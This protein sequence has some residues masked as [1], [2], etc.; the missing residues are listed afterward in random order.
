MEINLISRKSVHFLTFGAVFFIFSSK[1]V[2]ADLA[3]HF[4]TPQGSRVLKTWKAEDFK[5]IAKSSGEVSAL[6]FFETSAENLDWKDRAEIDLINIYGQKEGELV[7]LPRFMVVREWVK[8]HY[9]RKSGR[10]SIEVTSK[11]LTTIPKAALE[12]SSITKIELTQHATVYPGIQLK[13]RTNP[14][15]SRGEKLFTQNCMSC[16]SVPGHK[17][18]TPAQL[19]KTVLESGDAHH[20]AYSGLVLTPKDIRGLEAYRDALGSEKNDVKSPK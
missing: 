15:A 5:S 10:V 3:V 11:S 6:K 4:L 20:K 1:P 2:F 7:R 13:I 16:H 12:L 14:A 19:T 17:F 18:L 8:F 9:F